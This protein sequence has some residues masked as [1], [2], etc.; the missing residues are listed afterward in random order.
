MKLTQLAAIICLSTLSFTTSAQTVEADFQARLA[1]NEALEQII[2]A[3]IAAQPGSALTVLELAMNNTC[4]QTPPAADEV[5]TAVINAL[6]SD[7][8]QIES[9]LK[10]ATN[11]CID[12][13]SVTVIA[14]AAGVDP[15]LASSA[16]A[17]GGAVSNPA[18]AILAPVI[19]TGSGSGGDSGISEVNN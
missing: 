12:S 8:D 15:S 18:T 4:T 11:K 16:T 6:G 3:L 2:A 5:L 13:D 9:I 19:P 7:H 10:A 1:N 14:I 17:S